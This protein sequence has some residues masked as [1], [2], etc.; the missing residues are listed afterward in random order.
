[1][2][3]GN[4]SC[5]HA[6]E[7]I[8]AHQ[9][10]EALLDPTDGISR[11]DRLLNLGQGHEFQPAQNAQQRHLFSINRRER[12]WNNSPAPV[13]ERWSARFAALAGGFML[14]CCFHSLASGSSL[15]AT[16]SSKPAEISARARR[17]PRC[18]MTSARVRSSATCGTATIAPGCGVA[19]L[20]KPIGT[21]A[22][23]AGCAG[24]ATSI[25]PCA[26]WT[27]IG[28]CSARACLPLLF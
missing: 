7:Q 10:L 25:S 12:G 26:V 6:P 1:M 4:Q 8:I 2:I 24:A 5:L 9:L 16:R 14:Q 18:S 27:T 19:P 21:S 17:A 22:S 3:C 20:T 23:G 13:G 15:V 11:I 28:G